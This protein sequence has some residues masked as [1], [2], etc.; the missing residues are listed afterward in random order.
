MFWAIILS[1]FILVHFK[2]YMKIFFLFSGGWMVPVPEWSLA[3]LSEYFVDPNQGERVVV[4]KQQL[5]VR[6]QPT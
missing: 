2:R 1:F 3:L 5:R 6:P 4:S